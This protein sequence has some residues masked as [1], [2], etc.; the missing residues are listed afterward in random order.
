MQSIL[1]DRDPCIIHEDG[2]FIKT[3]ANLQ[4]VGLE[5]SLVS[6]FSI[7]WQY[8]IKFMVTQFKCQISHLGDNISTYYT[9]YLNTLF[10]VFIL[11]Q[12][13]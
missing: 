11:F 9:V 10:Y 3:G 13:F 6:V 2:R 7:A 8:I 12:S 1:V 5:A 4:S